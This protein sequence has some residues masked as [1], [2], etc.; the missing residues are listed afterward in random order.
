MNENGEWLFQDI[1]QSIDNILCAVNEKLIYL[2]KQTH[3]N[4]SSF[5]SY[6]VGL[7]SGIVSQCLFSSS[8]N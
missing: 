4:V 3:H 7:A 1:G 6:Y 8:G 2:A 5:S